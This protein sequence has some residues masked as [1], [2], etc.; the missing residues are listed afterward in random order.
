MCL[1]T[2]V[3]DGI[4][5]YKSKCIRGVYKSKRKD[6]RLTYLRK[7][8]VF[9][10]LRIVKCNFKEISDACNNRKWS[11]SLLIL[12]LVFSSTNALAQ[13]QSEPIAEPKQ[14]VV[15]TAPNNN[16]VATNKPTQSVEN[17]PIPPKKSVSTTPVNI[18]NKP[19]TLFNV[20]PDD[21]LVIMR[22]LVT[23]A[24]LIFSTMLIPFIR[25]VHNLR[26]VKLSYLEFFK[27]DIDSVMQRYHHVLTQDEL[28]LKY[29]DCH[30][31]K[32]WLKTLKDGGYKNEIP[33]EI[34]LI[35]D[36]LKRALNEVSNDVAYFPVITYT[37]M[38]STNTSH[39]NPLWKLK[40]EHTKVISEYLN[41]EV[42]VQETTRMLYSSPIF[43]WINS[44]DQEQ[45]MR[46]IR[47]AE[48][49]FCLLYT[50]DAADE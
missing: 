28:A 19:G 49:L 12:S 34:V 38:P 17:L 37:S 15:A 11:K 25:Y 41:S 46:W 8:V 4:L 43:D 44:N 31:N 30:M 21:A 13:T 9:C 47:G 7:R 39:D 18:V 48:S 24:A 5:R 26:S 10:I 27:A 2:V 23:I 33:H 3:I 50:S 6:F 42:E 20:D 35:D 29:P 1:I 14:D 40:R 36:L 16:S 32:P 45:R 22:M